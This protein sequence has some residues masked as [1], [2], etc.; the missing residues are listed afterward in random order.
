GDL[1]A[2]FLRGKGGNGA[3]DQNHYDGPVQHIVVEQPYGFP[4]WGL[5]KYNVVTHQYG[6]QGGRC[7][8]IGQAKDQQPFLGT[9]LEGPLGYPGRQELCDCRYHGHHHGHQDRLPVTKGPK[10]DQHAHP[11]QKEGDE[12]G[13]AH[14]IDPVHQGGGLGN[15]TVQGQARH[16]GADDALD[17]GQLGKDRAQV[18]HGQNKDILGDIIGVPLKKPTAHNGEQVYDNQGKGHKGK[19]HLQPKESAEVPIGHSHHHGQDQKGED[20]GDQGTAH[21]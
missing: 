12:D 19:G 1:L 7:L 6:R 14:K 17:P 16:K 4:H 13:V 8:G 21:R 15:K 3:G 10:V 2:A 9:E 20:I 11:D 18:H 5:P